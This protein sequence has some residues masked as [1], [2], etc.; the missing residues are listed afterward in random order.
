MDQL[1]RDGKIGAVDPRPA[2]ALASHEAG[3]SEL[4]QVKGQ[5]RRRDVEMGRDAAGSQTRWSRLHQGPKNLQPGLLGEGS[6]GADRERFFHN[7]IFMEI[8]EQVK[9][10][11]FL[12]TVS[13]EI[14]RHCLH[15]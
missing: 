3:T 10:C 8:S 9:Q 14:S 6:Q 1:V 2:L 11:I 5:R 13:T 4:L 7:S 15:D 12:L